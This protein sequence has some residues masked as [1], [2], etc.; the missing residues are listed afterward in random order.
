MPHLSPSSLL[1]VLAW[2]A[3]DPALRRGGA[4]PALPLPLLRALAA[5]RPLLAVLPQLPGGAQVADW[6]GAEDEAAAVADE[7]PAAP[8]N[9]PLPDG[10]TD[11]KSVV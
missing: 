10:P 5:R 1:L 2:D 8:A 11:R 9:V 4:G 7:T 6:G 3:A